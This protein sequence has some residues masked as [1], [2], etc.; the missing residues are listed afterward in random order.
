MRMS[1][2]K[3]Y[4]SNTH[5]LI[6]DDVVGTSSIEEIKTSAKPVI[7]K[8]LSTDIHEIS[9]NSLFYTDITSAYNVVVY[10]IN[11][12][13]VTKYKPQQALVYNICVKSSKPELLFHGHKVLKT[14]NSNLRYADFDIDDF[15][16]YEFEFFA[17]DEHDTIV[18]C[19]EGEQANINRMT[20]ELNKPPGLY[21]LSGSKITD[22]E[23]SSNINNLKNTDNKAIVCYDSQAKILMC[24]RSSSQSFVRGFVDREQI[25]FVNN[26]RLIAWNGLKPDNKIPQYEI[27]KIYVDGHCTSSPNSYS[28]DQ[29]ASYKKIMHYAKNFG[30]ISTFNG[31]FDFMVKIH[32]SIIR[33]LYEKYLYIDVLDIGIGKCRD[34]HSYSQYVNRNDIY[35]VEPN[36][37]F[38]RHCT[39]RNIFNSTADEIFKLF[40]LKRLNKKFHTIVFCNSYNFVTNPYITLKE[41][42]EVL[43]VNGRIIMVYMNNDKVTTI[44]NEDYEIRKGEHNSSLPKD[45]ILQGK[46][47]FIEV[48]REST[49]VPPHYENQ[50]S[51]SDILG[52]LEKINNDS[53]KQ[54]LQLIEKGTLIHPIYSSWLNENAK[55][56]NSM[57]YYAVIGRECKFDK[58]IIAFDPHTTT[59]KN[60]I[61]YLHKKKTFCSGVDIVR[62][63]DYIKNKSQY[64]S[65]VI[66]VA[67]IKEYEELKKTPHELLVNIQNV[68]ELEYSSLYSIDINEFINQR[69]KLLELNLP[70]TK[71]GFSV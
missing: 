26:F 42:E 20:I 35:G 16:D 70:H 10:K 40:K 34:V 13:Q 52:A 50:I 53:K 25:K 47:N 45:H 7:T 24:W 66:C 1:E 22:P 51:E 14:V 56:F 62:Y 31:G 37:D 36:N 21:I 55:L 48:F 12:I 71:F 5:F 38:S 6:P 58:I 17:I 41:C 32:R 46:Q 19:L 3:Y 33:D 60:F 8:S 4:F 9:D 59:L 2:F 64:T 68:A 57:F 61:D 29:D 15:F 65:P 43:D 18:E 49:L 54:P 30:N 63:L 28:I 27:V 11:D 44:K 69:K 23:W 39:I 67:S